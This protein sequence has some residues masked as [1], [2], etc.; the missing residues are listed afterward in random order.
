M[1]R[2]G[3]VVGVLMMVQGAVGQ[4]PFVAN[5]LVAVAGGADS[6]INTTDYD[7]IADSMKTLTDVPAGTAILNWSIR[8][9]RSS[10]NGVSFRIRPCGYLELLNALVEECEARFPSARVRH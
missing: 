7:D 10:S 5:H 9:Q 1:S 2:V 6:R 4:T 8:V 3:F